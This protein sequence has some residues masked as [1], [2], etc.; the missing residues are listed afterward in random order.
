MVIYDPITW[1]QDVIMSPRGNHWAIR[2]LTEQR[3]TISREGASARLIAEKM[4]LM[5]TAELRNFGVR[6]KGQSTYPSVE[7]H[8]EGGVAIDFVFRK[9]AG[10]L[11]TMSNDKV[12]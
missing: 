3:N 6:F 10:N 4:S 2:T 11:T 8:I 1:D 5:T 9:L 12:L 7:D